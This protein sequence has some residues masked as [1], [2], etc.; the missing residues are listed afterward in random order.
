MEVG[1]EETIFRSTPP[2][3]FLLP[4][5]IPSI[6]VSDGVST[7][8]PSL[9]HTF[10]GGSSEEEKFYHA[11]SHLTKGVKKGGGEIGVGCCTKTSQRSRVSLLCLMD[12]IVQGGVP[13]CASIFISFLPGKQFF[14][15]SFFR[16]N[17]KESFFLAKPVF[18]RGSF[19]LFEG[20]EDISLEKNTFLPQQNTCHSFDILRKITLHSILRLQT[21]TKFNFLVCTYKLF[22]S[23]GKSRERTYTPVLSLAGS[24][25][26]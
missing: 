19:S 13:T 14:P 4:R 10:W 22:S 26:N 9:S 12:G 7:P 8:P 15:L 18:V 11:D 16:E 25:K 21:T 23:C 6:H 3:F 17:G 24:G 1:R 5:C 2:H 20:Q